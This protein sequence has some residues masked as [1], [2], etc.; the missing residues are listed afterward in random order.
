MIIKWKEGS[1]ILAKTD[2]SE[3]VISANA[4]G[5]LSL[6]GILQNLASA[7]NGDHVHLDAYNALEEGS[8]DLIIEKIPSKEDAG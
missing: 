1:G 3:I 7:E 5:L 4:Q 2:G 6:A 8:A